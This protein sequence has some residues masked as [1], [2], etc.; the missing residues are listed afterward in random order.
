M[1]INFFFAN[2]IFLR[3]ISYQLHSKIVWRGVSC[4][5]AWLFIFCL[6]FKLLLQ[7]IT[8][9][10]KYIQLIMKEWTKED[11]QDNKKKQ[12]IFH[13]Y[14]FKIFK[15]LSSFVPSLLCQDVRVFCFTRQFFSPVSCYLFLLRV[16]TRSEFSCF[17]LISY[18]FLLD[19][20]T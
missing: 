13:E 2:E 8:T 20:V 12:F 6:L 15:I 3:R 7:L 18:S 5:A 11:L 1:K 4:S 9:Q 10:K 19:L 17:F 14:I 16:Q